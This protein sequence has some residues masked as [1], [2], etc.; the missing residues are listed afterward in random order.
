[1]NLPFSTATDNK[2]ATLSFGNQGNQTIF[3][4]TP[5]NP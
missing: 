1:M 2:P 5:Q 3:S 4:S